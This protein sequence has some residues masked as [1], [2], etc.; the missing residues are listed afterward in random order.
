MKL[1]RK[2]RA[3]GAFWHGARYL[4]AGASYLLPPRFRFGRYDEA[5]FRLLQESQWWPRERIEAYQNEQLRR[6]IDHAY[7][8]VP[9]YRRVFDERGLSPGQIQ[10]ASDLPKLPYLTK[11]ILRDNLPDLTAQNWPAARRQYVTTGGSTGVPVGFYNDREQSSPLEDAHILSIWGR[12]GYH[13]GDGSIQLRGAVVDSAERGKPWLYLPRT[14]RL[15]LS[16]YHL[17]DEYMPSYVEKIRASGFR[18]IEAYPSAIAILARFML[19]RKIEPIRSVEVVLCGSENL[20]AWQREAIEQAFRCRTFGFYGHSERAALS[21]ECERNADYHVVPEYGVTE[22]IGEDGRSVSGDGQIAEVIATGFSNWVTPFIRYRT[23]DRAVVRAGTCACGRQHQ[24]LAGIDGRLQELIVTGKGRL[25]SMTALNM[26]SDVFDEV[27]QFQFFQDTPGL[28]VFNVVRKPSYTE[29]STARIRKAL[30]AKLGDD[31]ELRVESVPEIP[32][33]V[34]GKQRF[35][36][37]KLPLK[38]GDA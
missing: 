3:W 2:G 1:P 28:V 33:T 31:V 5:M 37:Q 26:H 34:S 27:A 20:Y 19:E 24:L 14:R 38:F 7:R 17:T 22:L 10:D 8:N 30:L 35:L 36:I 21:A 15:V 16:S 18:F 4:R 12:V 23:A 9:Y 6:L 11:E 32:R 25:I 13:Y 29:E